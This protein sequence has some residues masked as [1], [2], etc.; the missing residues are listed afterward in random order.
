MRSIRAYV[1]TEVA[2]NREQAQAVRREAR[3]GEGARGRA[4]FVQEVPAHAAL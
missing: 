1:I 3:Q 2:H 4:H